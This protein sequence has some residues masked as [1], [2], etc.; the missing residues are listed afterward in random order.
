MTTE[1]TNS[2]DAGQG[3]LLVVLAAVLLGVAGMVLMLG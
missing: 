1:T 3:L 2:T